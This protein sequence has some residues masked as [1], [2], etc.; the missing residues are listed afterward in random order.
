MCLE[1]WVVTLS[2]CEF[3]FHLLMKP[4]ARTVPVLNTGLVPRPVWKRRSRDSWRNSLKL[5]YRCKE[6]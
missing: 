6:D 5:H 4:L 2:A 1:R 3:L